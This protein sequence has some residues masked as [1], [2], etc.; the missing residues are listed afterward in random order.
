MDGDLGRRLTRRG[1]PYTSL[2]IKAFAAIQG[3]PITLHVL[4]RYGIENYFTRAALEAVTGRD[5]S[6]FMPLP[7]HIG[8]EDHLVENTTW[9]YRLAATAA[10]RL[11]KGLRRG[12]VSFY[13]KD[14]N[15]EV[16]KQLTNA[17][18]EATD[19]GK[20]LRNVLTKHS[21]LRTA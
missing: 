13:R 14:L 10:P 7:H 8:I 6:G 4:D 21:R 11:L 2:A 17:D 15:S 1:K 12:R 18:I 20:I 3:F 9:F 16:A 5:L 19:L